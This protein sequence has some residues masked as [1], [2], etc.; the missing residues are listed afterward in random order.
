MLTIDWWMNKP[1]Y[2]VFPMNAEAAEI[3]QIV[4]QTLKPVRSPDLVQNHVKKS[5]FNFG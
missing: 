5:L 2:R 1:T 3:A 4:K